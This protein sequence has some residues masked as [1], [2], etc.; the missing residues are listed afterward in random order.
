[1]SVYI[2]HIGFFLFLFFSAPIGHSLGLPNLPPP[3]PLPLP[4]MPGAPQLVP[5]R[6]W[7]EHKTP[8]G[9]TYYYNKVT[10]QSGWEKP[11]DFELIMP[12]PVNF[13]VSPPAQSSPANSGPGNVCVIAYGVPVAS[14][15]SWFKI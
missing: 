1:M 13:G 2:N 7:S 9:K 10:R 15:A 14:G 4:G 3:F 6:V 11:K 12:L 5:T 8:E